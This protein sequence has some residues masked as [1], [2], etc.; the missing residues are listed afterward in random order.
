MTLAAALMGASLIGLA[1][2]GRAAD[3]PLNPLAEAAYGAMGLGGEYLLDGGAQAKDTAVLIVAKGTMQ[4]WDPGESESV[5]DLTKPDWGMAA[6]TNIW[7]R[8]KQFYRTEWTRPLAGGGTRSYTEVFSSDGGYVIGKDVNGGMPKRTVTQ[9][10]NQLHTMSSP[11][12]T[13]LL[14][15][16]ERNNVVIQMH[17]NPERVSAMPNQTAGGKS[18]PAVQYKGDYGTFIVMF[19]P[20]TK[21]P[22][23]VRS[24]EFDVLMGDADYDATLSDWRT[25][26]EYKMPFH[27]VETLNGVKIF[28]ISVDSYTTNRPVASDA[29]NVPFAMR[30]G[31]SKPMA[32]DKM[33]YQWVI[34]RLANGFYVDSNAMYTDDGDA[35][36]LVDAG[37]NISLASGGSHNTLIVDAGQYLVAFDSP[38]DDGMSQKVIEMAKAKYPGKSFKYLVLTHHHVD[39]TGGLRAYVADGATLIV[40]KGD[41]AFFK[42]VLAAPA[43][44]NPYKVNGSATANVIEVDGKW[45]VNDGGRT[46]EAYS[47]DNPHA[48]GYLIPYIPDAKMGFVTDLWNPGPPVTGPANPNMVAIVRGVEKM[49]IQPEKFAGGH[50]AI[51]NYADLANAVGK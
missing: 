29:F 42:G 1:S 11:R 6:F 18:Y 15:E 20:D 46:I 24:R 49:G 40:G 51:G 48:Q 26:G 4:Q 45:S 47:L 39:H 19:D 38:G 13:A 30:R 16:E 25:V 7:D 27:T 35:L 2:A 17:D 34:R 33:N 14:R 5:A 10:N 44:L 36:K 23:I 21:L 43:T 8:A 3:A 22:A 28:D 12:L 31:Q 41:G 37:P 9:N 32:A 50:G